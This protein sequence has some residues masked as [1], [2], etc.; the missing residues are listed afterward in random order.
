[1]VR[2]QMRSAPMVATSQTFLWFIGCIFAVFGISYLA[3]LLHTRR[4]K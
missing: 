3:A 2:V 4:L 1:M